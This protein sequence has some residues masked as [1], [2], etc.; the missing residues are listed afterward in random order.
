MLQGLSGIN[1]AN[2]R[3]IFGLMKERFYMYVDECGDQNLSNFEPTFPIFSLCGIIVSEQQN[4]ALK[5]KVNAMKN[6]FWGTEGIILHSRDI[7]KCQKGFE[8]LFNLDVKREFY[9]AVNEI[10]GETEAYKVVSCSI[11]KE[12]YIRQFGKLNDVYAQ[13]L[14]HLVERAIFYLDDLKIENGV[15]LDIIV[16]QRGKKEDQNLLRF[17]NRL[18]DA[19]T[20]WV[21]TERLQSHIR[22]FDFVPKSKNV[23]GLQIADLVAY[24]ITKHILEPDLINPAFS[25]LEPN[26]YESDGKRLGLKV[27]PHK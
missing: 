15:E 17:Y 7:R 23:V 5:E 18:R 13:S 27:I 25:I 4:N 8:I 26:I 21:S 11:L 9:N 12:D 1:T 10:L 2:V 22:R 16:E 6:R 3:I 19:G 24:P 14:S 20:Y